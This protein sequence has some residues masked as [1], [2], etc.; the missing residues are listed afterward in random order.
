MCKLALT[1]GLASLLQ[2]TNTRVLQLPSGDQLLVG[3]Q[4]FSGTFSL[5]G[6]SPAQSQHWRISLTVQGS[7]F[8]P[9][10]TKI[11]G[12]GND[13]PLDAAVDSAGDVWIAGE[14]D[15]DDFTLVNPLFAQIT[16][17]TLVLSSR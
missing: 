10:L 15:S 1:L 7:N 3:S 8:Q 16:V 17:H 2:A 11:G 14:T 13:I 12:S 5:N 6:S 4:L 9:Y